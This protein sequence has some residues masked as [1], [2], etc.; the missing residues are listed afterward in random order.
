M[1]EQLREALDD[2]TSHVSVSVH[3]PPVSP[4]PHPDCGLANSQQL[5]DNL[6][7]SRVR[8]VLSGHVHR[9]FHTVSDGITFL[10]ASSTLYQL[11]HGSDP[12]YTH[13]GQPPNALLV[14]LHDDGR[15]DHR[16]AV[17]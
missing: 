7:G 11:R 15:V 14:D 2:V 13:T 3:H 16:L 6:R 8:V 12:H 1:L 17:M 4:C 5:L 10:G 9:A